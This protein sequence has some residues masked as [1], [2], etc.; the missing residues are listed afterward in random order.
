VPGGTDGSSLN[1]NENS[2]FTDRDSN[3]VLLRYISVAW[4]SRARIYDDDDNTGGEA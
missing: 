3:R 4:P 2:R 1:T